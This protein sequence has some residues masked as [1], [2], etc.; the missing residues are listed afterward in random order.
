MALHVHK[1]YYN[2]CF[3]CPPESE[4]ELTNVK[5]YKAPKLVSAL[6]GIMV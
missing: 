2:A 6:T 5:I 1:A 4:L 3:R